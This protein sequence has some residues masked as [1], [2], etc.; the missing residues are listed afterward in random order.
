MW[1]PSVHLLYCAPRKPI[2]AVCVC[3]CMLYVSIY[4]LVSVLATLVLYKHAIT[5]T[6]AGKSDTLLKLGL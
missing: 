3:V 2:A 1:K 6:A 4:V 5:T